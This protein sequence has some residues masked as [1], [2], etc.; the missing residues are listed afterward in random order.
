[1]T[2]EQIKSVALVAIM[3]VSVLTVA[4][5]VSAAGDTDV[6]ISGPAQADQDEQV[7]YNVVVTNPDNGVG[8]FGDSS[9]S[10]NDTSVAEVTDVSVNDAFQVPTTSISDDASTASAA[11]VGGDGT[12]GQ[13]EVVLFTVTLQTNNPGDVEL[14]LDSGPIADEN[15]TDYTVQNV[16]GTTLT[17]AGQEDQP[18]ETPTSGPPD[19]TELLTDGGTFFQG[20]VLFRDDGVTAGETLEVR[21]LN[22][23]GSAGGLTDVGQISAADDGTVEIDTSELGS[24]SY[25]LE[26]SQNN[27]IASFEVTQ[28][29]LSVSF[30]DDTVD[31]G[32]PSSTVEFNADSNRASFRHQI[33]ADFGGSEILASDIAEGFGINLSA[34]NPAL[35]AVGVDPDD[36][37]DNEV[38]EID[39]TGDDTFTFDASVFDEGGSLNVT[40][41]AA[42]TTAE[43]TASV[44]V[45]DLGAGSADFASESI[46]DQR[47]DITDVT[48]EL[49]GPASQ[50]AVQFG[51]DEA[52]FNLSVVAT[53][54]D[55]DGEITF[56][57]NTVTYD[58]SVGA[59]DSVDRVVRTEVPSDVLADADYD[60]RVINGGTI[61]AEVSDDRL[62]DVELA[63]YG[64]LERS[65]TDFRTHTVPR[66]ADLDVNEDGSVT[67]DDVIEG[68]DAGVV[69]PTSDI[70]KGDRLVHQI[71]ASGLDGFIASANGDTTTERF[72]NTL[73]DSIVLTIEQDEPGRNQEPK[74]VSLDSENT[75][76][77]A[78]DD[79]YF[80]VTETGD[81]SAVPEDGSFTTSLEFDPAEDDPFFRTETFTTGFEFQQPEISITQANA[82]ASGNGT[83]T[84]S[85]TL[86]P[87]S[88]VRVT[89]RSEN[90]TI[91][92]VESGTT[93]VEQDGTFSIQFDLSEQNSGDTYSITARSSG[94][95]ASDEADGT[96]QAA[97]A[98]PTETVTETATPTP[99]ETATP[100]PTETATPTPTETATPTPTETATPTPTETAT[101]TPTETATPTPTEE[102]DTETPTETGT[103]TPGFT[104]VLG[105]VALLGA[106]LVALRRQD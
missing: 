36:D 16:E 87:G 61:P 59:D 102:P 44:Q 56:S 28:Q 30:A 79:Q 48:V 13:S 51:S 86:A 14:S 97:Q 103:S 46:Q 24:D 52:N 91:G 5:P 3:V 29:S 32:G 18:D 35:G 74:Q 81:V 71:V 88:Q 73:G 60:L 78:G 89:I 104:A 98:T 77:I 80:L 96:V 95:T 85:S 26:D 39:A 33:E 45:N 20:Q 38:L 2:R 68:L 17:V 31:N 94:V 43:D 7:T 106:A 15:D 72:F 27:V 47:G 40:V 58:V 90:A 11:G 22:D 23:D 4:T 8:F 21:F 57:L 67:A 65:T 9:V 101:P 6:A 42:D 62:N 49:S 66:D 76:V 100:T 53:D 105:V 82:T 19:G 1:M 50:A 37:G 84:G 25:V 93:T 12:T 41:T 54:G 64:L 69:T 70:A 34:T 99:T 92:F 10:V 63:T 55:D 75:Q 83:I